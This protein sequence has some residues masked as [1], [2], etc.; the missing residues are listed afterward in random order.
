MT[1]PIARRI[2]DLVHEAVHIV[3]YDPAWPSLFEQEA[4]VLRS[5]F[6]KPFVG[7]IEHFGSTAVPGLPSKPIID[8][9]VEVRSSEAAR[10]QIAPVLVDLGYE[11]FWRTDL[12]EHYAWFIKRGSNQNRSHHLHM[13][14]PDSDFW[15][16]IYF[17]DYL[18]QFPDVAAEYTELKQRLCA[19]HHNDRIGY[20]EGKTEFVTRITDK[21]LQYYGR[22]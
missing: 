2:E 20:T 12:E 22:R 8:I 14:E 15:K 9:I 18:R 1:D 4:N 17:R 16:R 5:L 3:P 21:A 13:V 7:R 19:L 10:T 11:Y 6:P